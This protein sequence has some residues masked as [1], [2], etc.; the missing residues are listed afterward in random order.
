MKPPARGYEGMV[1]QMMQRLLLRVCNNS[2]GKHKTLYMADALLLLT[3]TG[4]DWVC[5]YLKKGGDGY[6]SS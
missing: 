5:T 3:M 1:M 6:R 4:Q 2:G